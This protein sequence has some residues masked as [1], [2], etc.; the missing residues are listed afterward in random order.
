[1]R[2]PDEETLLRYLGPEGPGPDAAALEDHFDGCASCRA[3]VAALARTSLVDRTTSA[4]P[5]ERGAVET[6]SAWA[7]DFLPAGV[8][9]GRYVVQGRIGA[10]AMGVVYDA[11]D[12]ELRR[13]VAI[14]RLRAATADDP[15]RQ[16]R[17]LREAQSL[18]R[19]SHPNVVAVYDAG[20]HDGH[21]FLAMARV[22]GTT[23]RGWLDATPRSRA[24]IL[25]VMREVAEGLVAVHA[26]GLVHRDLKPD[27]V[28]VDTRGHA[29]VTDFGLVALGSAIADRTPAQTVAGPG[30]AAVADSP[31]TQTGHRVGTPRYM[32]PE[33]LVG[34]EVGPRTDQFAFCVV[35]FEALTGRSPFAG[36]STEQLLRAIRGRAIDPAIDALPRSLRRMIAQGLDPEPDRR[37]PG[38]REVVAALAPGGRR[39]AMLVVGLAAVGTAVVAVGI[40]VTRPSAAPSAAPSDAPSEVETGAS[41]ALLAR[42]QAEAEAGEFVTA[43]AT[44]EAAYDAAVAEDAWATATDAATALVRTVGVQ[45]EDLDDALRWHRHAEAG[46]RRLGDDP[47]RAAG[48]VD[49]LGAVVLAAGEFERA[50]DL[51]AQALEQ[52]AA[53]YG[54]DDPRTAVVRSHL[55]AALAHL[56]RIDDALALHRQALARLDAAGDRVERARALVALSNAQTES[57]EL[58]PAR[59]SLEQAEALLDGR[60]GPLLG[61]VANNLAIVLTRLGDYDAAAAELDAAQTLVAQSYGA[62]HPNVANVISGRANLRAIAGDFAGARVGFEQALALKERALG[63]DHPAL[64]PIIGNLAQI[65]RITDDRPSARRHLTRAAQLAR[66]RYGADHLALA[67]TLEELGNSLATGDA[68][69]AAMPV[70]DEAMAIRRRRVGPDDPSLANNWLAQAKVHIEAE[71]WAAT[72][73]ALDRALA[74]APSP[75][76]R[77]AIVFTRAESLSRRG[78]ARAAKRLAREARDMIVDR[79]D[80]GGLL[81]SIDGWIAAH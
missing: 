68:P 54:D 37:H 48:L 79:P 76:H 18:A 53:L 39:A 26:A 8:R 56:G 24:S 49:A 43:T 80:Q 23:L 51:F 74:I 34:D 66:A 15:G 65:A 35:M 81:A 62:E 31:L 29:L 3:V 41:A 71:D 25:A 6:A 12:P 30:V 73:A 78:D 64:L 67:T 75:G 38:M 32:A 4:S 61:R 14:K 1:M 20:I 77:A 57:G 55:G 22:E 13:A 45:A 10:G 44:L 72:D 17:L 27:N 33:Q 2:C 58:V 46:L 70:L 5:E 69:A 11:V 21:A 9:I 28:L 52:S 63:A 60:D 47:A 19:L 42:G 16:A 59:A 7:S 50:R 36:D 40:A